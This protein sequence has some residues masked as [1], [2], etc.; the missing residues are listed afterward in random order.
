[1]RLYLDDDIASLLL[2]RLLRK[3][4]HD[5]QLPVDAGLRGEDDPVH[6]TY[7]IHEDR[8]CLSGNHHDYENLHRLLMQAQ[9]HHPGILIVRRDNDPTKDLTERGIV[10]AITKLLS[11][12]FSLADQFQVLNHWR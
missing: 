12:G 1:M 7:A 9:G 10:R 5:V 8:V 6:L 3:A 11:A 4:G 2:L